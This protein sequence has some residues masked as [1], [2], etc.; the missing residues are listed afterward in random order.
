MGAERIFK[1]IGYDE[2]G[3]EFLLNADAYKTRAP[4]KLLEIAFDCFVASLECRLMGTVRS[5]VKHG[6]QLAWAK[7]LKVRETVRF[8]ATRRLL[9]D[10]A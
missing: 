6:E 2:T 8:C 10:V 4:T 1:L 9:K 7:V 3:D 5:L